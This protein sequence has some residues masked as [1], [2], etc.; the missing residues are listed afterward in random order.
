MP[1][2]LNPRAAC[3]LLMLLLSTTAAQAAIAIRVTP[4]TPPPFTGG[5]IVTFT[6]ALENL[7]PNVLLVNNIRLNFVDTSP[8]LPLPPALTWFPAG[9]ANP[10]LPAPTWNNGNFPP[11]T[12]GPQ[13]TVPVAEVTLTLPQT[14]GCF[15]LDVLGANDPTGFTAAVSGMTSFGAFTYTPLNQQLLDGHRDVG[16][17]FTGVELCNGVDDDC[18][19]LIDEDF[20]VPQWDVDT[21]QIIFVG[22]GNPCRIG[23]G[24]CE[25]QG[26]LI[27]SP[28]G[29]EIICMPV[30]TPDPPQPEGPYCTDTCYDYVDN[31][32]DGLVDEEDPD[33]QGAEV[34][35]G[36]DN[37]GDGQVDEGF[38]MLGEPCIV[39]EGICRRVGVYVC[40]DDKLSV[41]C[42]AMPGLG[43]EEGPPDSFRCNDGLDNDCDGLI[44]LDDPDC[45]Q[46]EICDG[47]DNDGDGMID[48]DFPLLG[49]PCIVGNGPCA[50]EGVWI[51]N[52]DGSGV[53]C[54]ATPLPPQP[55]GP[56]FCGCGDGI[57][58]DCDGLIDLD[59]P[60]CG[61][62][63]MR[64]QAA[65]VPDCTYTDAGDC[66]GRYTVDY[67]VING[68]GSVDVTAKVFYYDINGDELSS[69]DVDLGTELLLLS[70]SAV[71]EF[72]DLV[73]SFKYADLFPDAWDDMFGPD[74]DIV[75]TCTSS[76]TCEMLD[77]DCDRDFDLAD[78][79]VIQIE[80]NEDKLVYA[81]TTARPVLRVQADN[82]LNKVNAYASPVPYIEVH[83]PDHTVVPVNDFDRTHFEIALPNVD[84]NSLF[85]K[86]D[87]VDVFAAMGLDP[88]TDFPGGPY[89]GTVQLPNGCFASVCGLIV[90]TAPT[91]TLAS[92][93]LTVDVENMCCGGHVA[94]IT[95]DPRDDSG[96]PDPVPTFCYEDPFSDKGFSEGFEI[97]IASPPDLFETNQTFLPVAGSVCHGRALP[98]DASVGAPAVRLQNLVLA[99]AGPV[100][101]PGDGENAADT[102]RYTFTA[103]LPQTNLYQE[104]V[105][106]N[107]VPG[108][109]DPGSSYLIA[110]A[111]DDTGIAVRDVHRIA[112]GPVTPSAPAGA[113]NRT[114]VNRGVTLSVDKPSFDEITEAALQP[115][116]ERLLEELENLLDATRNEKVVIPVSGPCDPEI[117]VFPDNRPEPV[118]DVDAN[119]FTITTVLEN[120][121][122]TLTVES[123]VA[124]FTGSASG[125]CRVKVL[126]ICVF[127]IRID[128]TA[129]ITLQKA[130][131]EFVVFESDL[132]N[133]GQL[134]PTLIIDNNDFSVNV[135]DANSDVGCFLGTLLEVLS[136]GTINNLIE[137]LIQPAINIVLPLIDV[138]SF[139]GDLDVPPVPLNFL[140]FNPVNIQALQVAFAFDLDEVEITP[141]GIAAGI[142]TEFTPLAIDPEVVLLPGYPVNVAPLPQP[143][144]PVPNRGV[145]AYIA[146]DTVNQ[147][148]HALTR[149]GIL[150]TQFEDQRL[151]SDLFPGGCA[152]LPPI[153]EGQC[154]AVTTGTCAGLVGDALLSCL[155]TQ[156]ILDQLNISGNT[157]I[158]L[159]GR[160]DVAPKF[161]IFRPAAGGGDGFTCFLR[162]STVPV[163]LIADRDGDGMYNGDFTTLPSCFAGGATDTPCLLWSGCFDVNAEFNL[164]VNGPASAP[165]IDV[166]LVDF[167]LSDAM[168]CGGAIGSPGDEFGFN[169]IIEGQ[170][171]NLLQMALANNFP[172]LEL[173]GLDFGGIINISNFG[174]IVFGNDHDPVFNDYFGVTFDVS[175]P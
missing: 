85:L 57:D 126:G 165:T 15:A 62:T 91:G 1:T 25:V 135:V 105:L 32:C 168:G 103:T 35:D 67:Q 82:G 64:V 154:Q 146:D 160:M 150:I 87:G 107:Y 94:V 132:E 76:T 141:Q 155:G 10:N 173:P 163:A 50:Q 44:D 6:I 40:S 52:A 49:Q 102:Y 3:A 111:W 9:N 66:G 109:V 99:L 38:E 45:Q 170:V 14:A 43:K 5:Q 37:N 81:G 128:V 69:F 129:T 22:P 46:P 161:L 61:G 60:D 34:C 138:A 7:E 63:I 17:D 58:N 79:A 68:G 122:A 164:S 136:F 95:G 157:P 23:E 127:K 29:T 90:D 133:G 124:K 24:P 171:F 167:D 80:F 86:I 8:Q 21:G 116:V 101:T 20:V 134:V 12:L 71:A 174:D 88:A 11:L 56:A 28:D 104:V 92:N 70:R 115:I 33:C 143:I 152:A 120:N 98:I 65:L 13:S 131:V 142:E 59:D 114:P 30:E 112:L 27:C 42:S 73:F 144:L 78:F 158:L 169:E 53:T 121:K 31:D 48:E 83:K 113:R 106:G 110:E 140:E 145:S 108:S 72:E 97:E 55:E 125:F 175:A 156:L 4:N 2:S 148:L 166:D 51:C 147:L 19:G 16:V 54:S 139:V 96:Y 119:N 130:Q 89:A 18:D 41:V 172:P 123:P 39:G 26:R 159:H 47:L 100:I 93:T 84:P 162:I 75:D 151:L 118:L 149:N 74:V 77:V 36:R 153:A 137:A 117:T